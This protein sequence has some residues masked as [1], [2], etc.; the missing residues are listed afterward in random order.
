MERNL[1]P[2]VRLYRVSHRISSAA[3]VLLIEGHCLIFMAKMAACTPP[4]LYASVTADS[5]LMLG[6]GGGSGSART[7]FCWSSSP[8]RSLPRDPRYQPRRSILV[9]D[10]V[11]HALITW[12]IPCIVLPQKPLSDRVDA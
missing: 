8:L 5:T 7:R 4:S 6:G 3:A 2:D 12:K 9:D 11:V 10:Q 1:R